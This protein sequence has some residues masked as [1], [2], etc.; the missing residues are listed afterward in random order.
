[1]IKR[2]VIPFNASPI[3]VYN[4]G[5]IPTD[6]QIDI[7]KNL[8]YWIPN[9][10][11][12]TGGVRVSDRTNILEIKELENIDKILN[13]CAIDY[14]N[15]V[16]ELEN[17]FFITNSWST[18]CR[19]GEKH[20]PHTHPNALFSFVYYVTDSNANLHFD[21]VPS[22]TKN[23]NLLYKIKNFNIYNSSSWFINA[24]AGEAAFFLGDITHYTEP[25]ESDND[26]I[27]IGGNYFLKGTLGSDRSVSKMTIYDR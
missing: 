8:K 13:D 11:N 14:M 26:R 21:C 27:I 20:H 10:K 16:L 22:I 9:G 4:T 24:K 18:I 19:K 1:M 6:E 7:I 2:D 25:N 3:S 12:N 15:N 23:M 5:T 17:E